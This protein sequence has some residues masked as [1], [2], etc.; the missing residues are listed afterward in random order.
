MRLGLNLGATSVASIDL[1]SR[2]RV[3][4][5]S[6]GE[7]SRTPVGSCENNYFRKRTVTVFLEILQMTSKI[8]KLE[9]SRP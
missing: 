1:F 3:L 4:K 2:E 6:R 8:L 5:Q 9:M 7:R